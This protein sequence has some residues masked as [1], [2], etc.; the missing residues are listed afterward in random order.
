MDDRIRRM[1][2]VVRLGERFPLPDAGPR[3]PRGGVARHGVVLTDFQS[4]LH[5]Q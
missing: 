4:L 5:C 3:V 2:R 1:V